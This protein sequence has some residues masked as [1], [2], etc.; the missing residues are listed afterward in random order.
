M[1]TP[2]SSDAVGTAL[3]A[4]FRHSFLQYKALADRALAQLTDAEWLHQPAPG[5]NSVAVIVQHMAGNLRS[6]FT[7]FLT[8]DGE[9]PTRQRD[10]EFEEPTSPDAVPAL[11]QE[12]EAAWRVLFVLLDELRAADLLA[13]VTI[14]GEDHTVLAAVQRQVAHY[15]YHVGQLVQLA[16]HQRGEAFESLSIP[17]GQSRQFNHQMTSRRAL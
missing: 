8:T 4:S 3:L 13:T 14:R 2:A 1:H 12:W 5:A 7:D 11:R 16:K 15:A 10:Q 17:R 9:K 6:R